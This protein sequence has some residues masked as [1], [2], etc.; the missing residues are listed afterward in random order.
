[1]K[2]SDPYSFH[3]RQIIPWYDTAAV[4]WTLIILMLAIFGF[5]VV[6][7]SVA[8]S[9]ARFQAYLWVPATLCVISATVAVSLAW[10]LLKRRF[11][12][13]AG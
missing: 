12:K 5:A 1:M 4:C 11:R 10:H 2:N 13:R 6:G 8:R 9:E 7:I 3:N